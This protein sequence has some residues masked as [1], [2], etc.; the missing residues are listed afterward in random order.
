MH[1]ERT[2]FGSVLEMWRRTIFIDQSGISL[3]IYGERSGWGFLSPSQI[4]LM[5]AVNLSNNLYNK[6]SGR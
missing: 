1:R 2:A 5:S 6:S 4:F 3:G